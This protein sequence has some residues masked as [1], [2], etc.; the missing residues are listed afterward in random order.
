MSTSRKTSEELEI[1]SSY[2]KEKRLRMT[3]Q[4]ETVV[5]CFLNAGGHVSA[6]ELYELVKKSDAKIGST[7]VF[8]TLKALTDCGLAREVDLSDGRIRFEP[9]HRRPHHHH[10][11]CVE[12]NRTIEFLSPELEQIQSQIVS[13]Y[14]F[15]PVQHRVQIYGICQDCQNQRQP[16][17]E[18]V[19]ADLVFV[20]DALKIAME[21]EKRGVS[22]YQTASAIVTHQ[23]TRSTF[24]Q[25]LE[26]EKTH[27][28]GLE[29]EWSQLIGEHEEVLEAPVF[30]HFDFGSLKRIFP[31]RD[32]IKRK[33]KENL[34]ARDALKLA[35]EMERDAYNFFREYAQ[36]FN[37]TKG[38]DI[39]TQF[40]E[41][42]LEH[43]DLIKQ[44]YEKF[45]DDKQAS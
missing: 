8:R 44:E 21:T 12:C 29:K 30:L 37:E 2:L 15:K 40:A 17:P 24:L 31:S 7:T 11:V 43:Y 27:L 33:L 3:H 9:L 28:S 13:E 41:E 32:Q 42:E 23:S 34:S 25:M 16:G 14:H 22:F 5:E 20:R 10:M 38:K 6:E 45:S 4:R 35:M 26:D 36:K 18:A 1:F 39:F 19:D